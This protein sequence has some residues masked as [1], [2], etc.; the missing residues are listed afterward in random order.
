MSFS[1]VVTSAVQQSLHF[2]PLAVVL[3]I[4]ACAL[5]AEHRHRLTAQRAH[6]EAEQRYRGVIETIPAVTYVLRLGEH[7]HMQFVAPQVEALTGFAPSRWLA[8]PAFW[9]QR[10]HPHDREAV[11][12]AIQRAL[13]G[14]GHL[15]HECRVLAADGRIVWVGIDGEMSRATTDGVPELRGFVTDITPRRHAD[16]VAHRLAHF[17]RLTD[18]PNR[19]LFSE[20]LDERLH[21]AR[22]N[23]RPL[24]LVFVDVRRVRE[25]HHSLGH[26][27]G[28]ALLRSVGRRLATMDSHADTVTRFV[29]DT[30][31]LLVPGAGAATAWALAQQVLA[32]FDTPVLLEDAPLQVDPAIGIAVYP[33]HGDS[34]DVLVQ[35]AQVACDLARGHLR[36]PVVYSAGC[37]CETTRHFTLV[38]ELRRALEQR[39]LHLEYQPQMELATGRIS[40][41]EALARWTH[42]TLGAVSPAEF[43]DVAEQSGLIGP[44]TEWVVRDA[45]RQARVWLD[46]GIDLHIAVNISQRSLDD[47]TFEPFLLEALA[48]AGVD[49]ARLQLE[50]TETTLVEHAADAAAMLQ[51]LRAHGVQLSIDEFGTGHSSMLQLRALPFGEVKIDRSFVADLCASRESEE[52]VRFLVD[53]AH[54]LGTRVVAEGVE[55]AHG[56]AA[57]QHLGCDVAQGVAISAALSAHALGPWIAAA[58]EGTTRVA[59]SA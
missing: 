20:R 55:T 32:A 53:L 51:R 33:E 35:H 11:T 48:E 56:L 34:A 2:L 46:D 25:V 8:D 5:A 52:I 7:W 39:Q 14:D 22:G 17:D 45:L 19:R 47:P 23:G 59:R 28:D 26:A 3:L 4:S 27:A 41:V 54:H 44:L 21:E 6:L 29:G 49:P 42:P 12:E 18:L 31:A 9:M 10:I 1:S 43:I 36:E 37:D 38:T 15:R 24:A 30:F 58:G 57:A 16:Q 40:G 13:D 50:F